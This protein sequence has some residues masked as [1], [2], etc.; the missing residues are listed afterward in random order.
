MIAL[1]ST[2]RSWVS[3]CGRARICE[4]AKGAS[5]FRKGLTCMSAAALLVGSTFA[6]APAAAQ[7]P[8]KPV[9]KQA[10]SE[11][12]KVAHP[13]IALMGIFAAN[14]FAQTIE[15]AAE[16]EAK[17]LG[18]TLIYGAPPSFGGAKQVPILD[19]LLARNPNAIIIDPDNST[20][21]NP[22][23]QRIKAEGIP[24]IDIDNEISDKSLALSYIGVNGIA[25]GTLA[26]REMG[27]LLHGRGS[28][29]VI[30]IAPGNETSIARIGGFLLG[31][32]AFPEVKVVATQYGGV[33]Q[34]GGASAAAALLTR[35]H[36]LNGIFCAAGLLAGGA[37]RAVVSAG[38]KGKVIVMGFD[39]PPPEVKLLEEHIV[40]ATV[41]QQPRVYG[42]LGVEYAWD[43]VE[44]RLS[45]IKKVV[46]PPAIFATADEIDTPRIKRYWY[47]F[48]QRP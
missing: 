4:A 40:S 9:R 46:H 24:I 34:S 16:R 45:S 12:L 11:P 20:E 36:D 41:I 15:R 26:G 21:L 27:K 7:T 25:A 1:R 5:A 37:G 48:T 17:R 33:S 32:K 8:A 22:T 28:V 35:Y 47:T 13:V 29:A 18:A 10:S 14:A 42:K 39:A 44:G 3:V 6:I 2:R 31:L 43:A 23:L 19:A 38:E 30:G